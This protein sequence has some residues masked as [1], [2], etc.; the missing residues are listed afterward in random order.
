VVDLLARYSRN[1]E[2][3]SLEEN[4]NMKNK[5]VCIIGCGGLGGYVIEMLARLGVGKLI[6]V[7]GD[8]FEES[9]LNRQIL[10]ETS[11]IGSS[12]ALTA[13]ERVN[14]INP[15]VDITAVTDR[16]TLENGTEIIKKANVV[17][18]ALDSVETRL[19]LEGL[20]EQA[21]IPLV[22]GAIG[23]WYGQ[24]TSIMPGDKTLSYFYKGKNQ[25]GIE[26]KL[27]NPSFTPALVASIEV[28]EVVKIL[29]SRGEI[30][31]QKML[32]VDLL[33]NDY[34]V[35]QLNTANL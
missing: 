35:I 12:K 30:L 31:S 19:I 26:T 27:G 8:I 11:K 21:N 33:D 15:Y 10:S 22:H 4:D 7:D 20:C 23:G 29:I 24:V 3:L 18:D 14:K 32:I 2:T 16:L 6:A 1:V 28:S 34:E 17:V 25:K 9:N 5:T 13:V